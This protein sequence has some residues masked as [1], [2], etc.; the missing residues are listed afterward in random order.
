[1]TS[2]QKQET[3]KLLPQN[4]EAE[5]SVLGALMMDRFAMTKVADVVASIDFYKPSH[6]KIFESM[7]RLYEKGE[8]IDLVSV[9]NKLKERGELQDVGGYAYL[10]SLVNKVPTATHIIH[11]AKIVRGKR[12]LRDLISTANTVA[13]EAFE[14]PEDIEQF[15]DRAEQR[16]FKISQQTTQKQFVPIGQDLPEAFGRIERLQQMEEGIRG[17]PSGYPALDNILSGFQK[18]D[19][20]VIGARPSLGKTSLALAIARQAALKSQAPVGILS[21]EMSREQVI[22]R[23]ISAESR[24][25]L[26]KLRTGKSLSELEFEMLHTALDRLSQVPIFIDDTTSPNILQIRAMARR[27]QAE[28]GLAMLVVDYL[29]LIQPR[30][31][32]D[33]VVQQMSEISRSLKGVARELDIPVIA[34]S[35][36][37]RSVDNREIKIPRLSDLRDSGS[38]EQDSD[39]VMFIHRKD[40][41]KLEISEEERNIAEIHVAKHRNGP[42][43]IIRLHFDQEFAT[44]TTLET[45][46]T[47]DY[48]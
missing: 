27:L 5:E 37:S 29:Q 48:S 30:T 21:L 14:E 36:L 23:L 46:M 24:V 47:A 45:K 11:Y 13:G 22:D 6:Q 32:S 1:M 9:P 4:I 26:W 38:I 28:R 17:I 35:Q 33:N 16:F 39:V 40:R 15:L 3:I 43:G 2:S 10:S 18:S 41:D 44:F 12:I 31:N 20:I 8:P 7:L 25:P 42:L 19:L 34:L